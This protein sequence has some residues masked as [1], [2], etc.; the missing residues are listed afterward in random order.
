MCYVCVVWLLFWITVLGHVAGGKAVPP[1]NFA[2]QE[3][4]RIYDVMP[5]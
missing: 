4:G 1:T 5:G 2:G 3:P